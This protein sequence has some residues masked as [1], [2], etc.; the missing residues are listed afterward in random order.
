MK[1]EELGI[2]ACHDLL[3]RVERGS[4]ACAKQNQP[5][6]TPFYFAYHGGFIH[7][8]STV[9]QKIEWMRAN[10]LVCVEA[11]DVVTPQE[12]RSVIV[13][14]RYEELPD[15]SQWSDDRQLVHD[16]LQH[17]KIWWEPGYAKTMLAGSA[18]PL[19]PVFFRIAID[20]I[21]GHRAC[22]DT[23]QESQSPVADES[24]VKKVMDRTLGRSRQ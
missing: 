3:A 6:V 9:G 10:P 12:W 23:E 22:L 2:Q 11:H 7:A 1:I 16:L 21:T 5:Y 14:G 19:I 24:W 15:T 17:R 4:L 13:F 18:R 20:K 8:F